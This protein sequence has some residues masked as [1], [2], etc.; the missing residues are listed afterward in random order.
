MDKTIT[1]ELP[2][3]VV[4]A[5]LQR[6]TDQRALNELKAAIQPCLAERPRPVSPVSS[7]EPAELVSSMAFPSPG[8][9][10]DDGE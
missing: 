7:P 4:K 5:W 8:R 6:P 2:V 3:A 9:L 10:E 1:V